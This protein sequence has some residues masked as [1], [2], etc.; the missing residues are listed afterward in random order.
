MRSLVFVASLLLATLAHA[1]FVVSSLADSG[2][3]TLRQAVLDANA[4][5]GDNTIT[6][7]VS[8][9]IVLS[10]GQMAITEALW[11]QGPGAR[12]LTVD[13]NLTGR[14]FLI[15]GATTHVT[16]SGMTLTGGLID[17]PGSQGGSIRNDGGNLTLSF[18]RVTD[19]QTGTDGGAI[20][21]PFVGDVDG[22]SV[23]FLTIENS[24]ISLNRA[25]KS[26]GI[27]HSGFE[28]RIYNSTIH[29]NIAGDSVGGIHEQGGFATIRNSTISGNNATFVG[30][31]LMEGV[32]MTIE[33]TIFADNVDSSGANDINRIAGT[34]NAANSLFEED[35][36][37]A[38][39]VI[40]GTGTNNLIAVESQLALALS[41]NGGPTNS[42]RPPPTSPAVGAGSNSSAFA[43]DQRGPGFPRDAGGAVDIGA[44]QSFLA[45]P[46][47]SVPV[48]ALAPAALGALSLL[49]A[50]LGMRR[51]R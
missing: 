8:G 50:F 31:V 46:P 27:F 36:N 24:E 23:N 32:S 4:T 16:L 45:P 30:G 40:N 51:R 28:L 3:G 38:P 11:I 34:V 39:A 44:I 13:A 1:Q 48:P 29:N 2:P 42:L 20:Y 10:T 47:P 49:L 5:P 14:H 37:A 35:I 21:D 22:Q 19:N 18:M 9:T 43:F 6:F 7:T 25:G 17:G 12:T 26:A 41:N 15:T 33:S